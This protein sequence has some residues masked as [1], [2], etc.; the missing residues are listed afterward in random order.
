[1][2]TNTP[3]QRNSTGLAIHGWLSTAGQKS[4]PPVATR[5]RRQTG[6]HHCHCEHAQRVHGGVY[7]DHR[8]LGAP[9]GEVQ[10]DQRGA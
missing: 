1:M 7:A 5:P 8:F 2:P 10:R 9:F 3:R 6:K 4:A